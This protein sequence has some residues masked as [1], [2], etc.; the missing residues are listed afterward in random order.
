MSTMKAK[1][2]RHQCPL[3]VEWHIINT[4]L[5][6]TIKN[7]SFIWTWWHGHNVILKPCQ[8]IWRKDQGHLIGSTVKLWQYLNNTKLMARVVQKIVDNVGSHEAKS[9]PS[10]FQ[11]LPHAKSM[12]P[13]PTF[14]P[15][16]NFSPAPPHLLFTINIHTWSFPR[17]KQ[18]DKLPIN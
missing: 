2:K 14:S 1:V 4:G 15:V 10:W 7:I 5:Q 17:G 11:S 18:T 16:L 3:I 8:R 9:N 12:S 13:Y 6:K